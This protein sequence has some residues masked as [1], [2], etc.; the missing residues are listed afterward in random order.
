MT[1]PGPPFSP[2]P[3]LLASPWTGHLPVTGPGPAAWGGERWPEQSLGP[4]ARLSFPTPQGQESRLPALGSPPRAWVTSCGRSQETSSSPLT[5]VF[6]AS[7]DPVQLLLVRL[8]PS[9]RP[10]VSVS[11][12]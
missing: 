4:V 7:P 11:R 12:G 3:L 1:Q 10:S 6:L 9:S 2:F 8:K 5:L